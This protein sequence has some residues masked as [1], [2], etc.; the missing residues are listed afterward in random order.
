[1]DEHLHHLRLMLDVLR[2]DKLYAKTK[3]CSFCL[4]KVVFLGFIVSG[5][6]IEVD[7]EK[8]KAIRV[9]P[10]PKNASKVRS[11]HGLASFYRRFVPHF[12]YITAPL[13]ELV[14]KDV[15]FEWKKKHELA[16]AK[17]K[18]KLCFTQLLS[19]PDFD[20]TFEIE[21]DASGVVDHRTPRS[22]VPAR[23]IGEKAAMFQ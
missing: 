1:M 5:K 3:K 10:T 23:F 20:K 12:S 13:N 21:S 22:A 19:V 11:F 2:H 6:G 18:D 4:E 9:W 15:A 7:E 14:K 16:F 17:L 8:V